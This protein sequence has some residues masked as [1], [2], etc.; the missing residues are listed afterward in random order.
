MIPIGIVTKDRVGYLDVTLK[1]LSGTA[2]PESV[3]VTLFDDGSIDPKTL[4]YYDTQEAIADQTNWPDSE[5]WNRTLGLDI[6]RSQHP[7]VGING[8]LPIVRFGQPAGVVNASL[9][10][11]G[12]LF[13]NNLEAPWA[14]LLQDDVVFKADW[15]QRLTSAALNFC[16][17]GGRPGVIAG[18]T[19]NGKKRGTSN[20]EHLFSS[21][22]TAQCLCISRELYSEQKSFFDSPHASKKQFDGMLRNQAEKAGFWV[23]SLLPFVCQHICLLYTSPSPRDQRGSRMPSSA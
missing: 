5:V 2:I 22:V 8:C 7:I 6:V 20:E 4:R 15:Y 11:I 16:V 10:V 17:E 3:S 21:K 14:I 12:H 19:I 1:S 9:R 18:L 23:G 13:E